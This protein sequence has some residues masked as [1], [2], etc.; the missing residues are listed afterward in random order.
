MV[1]TALELLLLSAILCVQDGLS[2]I[3]PAASQEL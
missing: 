1:E 3:A 2:T